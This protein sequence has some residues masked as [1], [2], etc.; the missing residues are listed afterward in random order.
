MSRRIFEMFRRLAPQHDILVVILSLSR[1]IFEMFRR[2]APQH[3]ILVVIL[4]DDSPEESPLRCF[5]PLNM[6]IWIAFFKL[7]SS[8]LF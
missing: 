1:R 7:L 6:T 4:R 5:A 8:F 2:L 3:D